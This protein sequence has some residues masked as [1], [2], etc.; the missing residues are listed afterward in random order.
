MIQQVDAIYEHSVF[1]PLGSLDLQDQEMVSLSIVKRPPLCESDQ[2]APT[3]FELLD[4][5][6]LIG[7]VTD[8]PTDLSTNPK[9]MEGFGKSKSVMAS[10]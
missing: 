7:Y 6:G 9:Y 3:L 10:S 2:A 8:A 4:A 1:K 5:A